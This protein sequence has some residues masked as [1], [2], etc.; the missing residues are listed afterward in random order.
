[1]DKYETLKSIWDD[2]E[3][4][5]AEDNMGI[6]YK[7]AAINNQFQYT[8]VDLSEWFTGITVTD[9]LHNFKNFRL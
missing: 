2:G 7:F 3:I 4:A 9:Y 8:R 1:M 5:Y 6:I